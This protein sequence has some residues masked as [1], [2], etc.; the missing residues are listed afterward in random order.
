MAARRITK[1]R[2]SFNLVPVDAICSI[3]LLSPERGRPLAGY[4][5]VVPS[6]VEKWV[7]TALREGWSPDGTID[8][9]IDHQG[10]PAW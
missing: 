9:V 5:V 7:K 3:G 2:P 4:E 6:I 8:K 1:Y 10:G